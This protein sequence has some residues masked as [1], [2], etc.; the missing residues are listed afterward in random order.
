MSFSA[1]VRTKL[2]PLSSCE[3][4]KLLVDEEN[5]EDPQGAVLRLYGRET[6]EE[7]PPG[8]LE[9]AREHSLSRENSG[10]AGAMSRRASGD[11]MSSSEAQASLLGDCVKSLQRIAG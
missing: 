3:L 4:S 10:R 8:V 11:V 6:V 1:E 5:E 9:G 7:L 2:P